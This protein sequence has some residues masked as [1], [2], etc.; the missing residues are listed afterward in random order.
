MSAHSRRLWP[1]VPSTT[2]LIAT[3]VAALALLAAG[4]GGASAAANTACP[5]GFETITV[6]EAISEGYLT[7]PFLTDQAGNDDGTVCRR[8]LGD[9]IFHLFSNATVDTIYEWVD[10]ATPRVDTF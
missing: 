8:P 1:G 10:N 5:A 4:A 2:R 6:A 7:R 9:G 3:F